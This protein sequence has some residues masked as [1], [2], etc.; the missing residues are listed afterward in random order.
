[1]KE[2][3]DIYNLYKTYSI[4][5]VSNDIY[6]ILD[7]INISFSKLDSI[8]LKIGYKNDDPKRIMATIIYCMKNVCFNNGDT[9]LTKMDIL[10]SITSYLKMEIS[11]LDEYLNKLANTEKIYIDNDKYYLKDIW[12]DSEYIINKLKYLSSI[13]T[14]NKNIKK[15]IDT[16][17]KNKKI[18]YN[19]EQILAIEKA[20]LSNLVIITGGPGVGKTTIIKAIT[21]LYTKIYKKNKS[22]IVLL[23]PTGRGAKRMS[24]DNLSASTI[25]RF[26]KWNKDDNSFIFNEFNKDMH[27][28]IIVDEVSMVD[29]SL[30]ASLLK[31]IKDDVKLVLVGDYNQLPSVGPGNIL[32]DLIDS[33]VIET[34][35]LEKLYRQSPNSYIPTL[36]SDIKNNCVSDFV[37]TLDDY[38]FLKCESDSIVK[39]LQNIINKIKDKDIQDKVMVMA[40]MYKGDVGIDNLNKILQNIINP[41]GESF[42]YGDTLYRVG[43]KILELVNMPDD[44]VFNGDIGFITKIDKEKNTIYVSFDG[45]IVKYTKALMPNI[46]LGY[47]ISIHKSQGSEFDTVILPMTKKYSR[48]LYKKLIY[49]AVTRAKRKLIILGEDNAFLYACQNNREEIRKTDLKDKLINI[50]K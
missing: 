3:L 43:D 11:D 15:E 16:Y 31:G 35:Y 49:T 1:M 4:E 38:T 14:D 42:E 39:N 46:T 9:Y 19:E 5:T 50:Y 48:M 32:K 7:N 24:E 18:T 12:D 10:M 25:H 40:P 8:A 21:D 33:E 13:P 47:V 22:D 36:A 29:I 17:S 44:N 30:F 37:K 45:N 2:A 27:D 6:S 41:N 34:V 26:L 28:M 23:A 20:I